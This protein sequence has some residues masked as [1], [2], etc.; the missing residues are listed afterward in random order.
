MIR[1]RGVVEHTVQ[2]LAFAEGGG[3]GEREL[4][5]S[6]DDVSGAPPALHEV[7]RAL[8]LEWGHGELEFCF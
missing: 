1:G 5:A 6:S 4:I 8:R 7:L 2:A 3:Q